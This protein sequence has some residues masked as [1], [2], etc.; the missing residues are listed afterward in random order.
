MK[1]FPCRKRQTTGLLSAA[2]CLG[3]E[4]SVSFDSSSHAGSFIH[5]KRDL[6]L[7]LMRK[8]SYSGS[9]VSY[10]QQLGTG[11][12]LQRHFSQCNRFVSNVCSA[13]T[14]ARIDW[15]RKPICKKHNCSYLAVRCWH[16]FD[17]TTLQ[18]NWRKTLVLPSNVPAAS[19]VV[20]SFAS[21]QTTKND[22]ALG[23]S[24]GDPSGGAPWCSRFVF[25]SASGDVHGSLLG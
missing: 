11:S 12:V 15:R 22:P 1:I 4:S 2:W 20:I 17:N 14:W 9:K 19:K 5:L 18:S 3:M 25:V 16:V 6:F 10:S 8:N 23:E 13:V 24:I 7:F 21:G